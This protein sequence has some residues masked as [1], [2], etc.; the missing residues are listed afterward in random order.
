[1]KTE[2]INYRPMSGRRIM[3][4]NNREKRRGTLVLTNDFTD[5]GVNSFP[6]VQ[7]SRIRCTDIPIFVEMSRSVY[8]DYRQKNEGILS[9]FK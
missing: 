2:R 6:S 8:L 3:R 1:M 9:N 7:V 5:H 4:E